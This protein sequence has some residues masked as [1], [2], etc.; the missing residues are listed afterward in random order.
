MILSDG[1]RVASQ[2][3]DAAGGQDRAELTVL[4][5]IGVML[6]ELAYKVP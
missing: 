1:V 3:C 5:R 4:P 2:I 6:Q